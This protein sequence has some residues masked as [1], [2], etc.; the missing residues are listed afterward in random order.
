[1]N[2]FN[3]MKLFT[4]I[5]LVFLVGFC[6]ADETPMFLAE[7]QG[8]LGTIVSEE[9]GRFAVTIE[10]Y[11]RYFNTT[12]GNSTFSMP[13]EHL[14]TVLWP[15]YAAITFAD[16]NGESVSLVTVENLSLS[17]EE[18]TLKLQVTPVSFYE[19]ELLTAFAEDID[20]LDSIQ[21]QSFES[22]KVYFEITRQI[23]ENEQLCCP[24]N[25]WLETD[26]CCQNEG[27]GNILC[28]WD[29]FVPCS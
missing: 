11:D 12:D 9:D 5:L 14:S 21:N 13:V 10:N 16:E 19:G 18:N 8:G 27:Q 23:P 7:V 4:I 25:H 17:E 6:N 15:S 22:T 1:M 20:G 2:C 3:I 24:G 29:R 28:Y 26:R